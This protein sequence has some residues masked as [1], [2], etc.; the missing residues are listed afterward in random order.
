MC[1]GV[2][3]LLRYLRTYWVCPM[4]HSS[5]AFIRIVIFVWVSHFRRSVSDCPFTNLRLSNCLCFVVNKHKQV[6]HHF[7]LYFQFDLFLAILVEFTRTDA[8]STIGCWYNARVHNGALD[9]RPQATFAWRVVIIF[10][11]NTRAH[12]FSLTQDGSSPRWSAVLMT[13]PQ[14]AWLTRSPSKAAPFK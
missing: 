9:P 13:K 14:P 7:W 4:S 5:F 12:P 10:L 3:L 11:L 1:W 2:E 8:C 6:I